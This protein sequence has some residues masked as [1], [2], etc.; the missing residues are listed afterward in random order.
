[1]KIQEVKK[2]AID[3]GI[4]AGKMKKAELIRTIQTKEGNIPCYQT[5]AFD[6]CA[7]TGCCWRN[8]CMNFS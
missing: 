8:E 5:S 1:M 2:M 3:K 6:L 7:Q 4:K